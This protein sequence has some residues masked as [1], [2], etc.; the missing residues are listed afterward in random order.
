MQFSVVKGSYVVALLCLLYAEY[1]A[2]TFCLSKQYV[3][4]LFQKYP[5]FLYKAH[6]TLNNSNRIVFKQKLMGLYER[7]VTTFFQQQ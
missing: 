6:N 5:S 4:G 7:Y 2:S 3:R 1:A